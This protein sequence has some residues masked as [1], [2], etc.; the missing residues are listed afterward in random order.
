MPIEIQIKIKL[1]IINPELTI[2]NALELHVYISIIYET[3]SG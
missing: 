1:R 2:A 3:R